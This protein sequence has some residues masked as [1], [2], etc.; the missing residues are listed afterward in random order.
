MGQLDRAVWQHAV[1]VIRRQARRLQKSLG[2]L[3]K[4]HY[5]D[6]LIA[7][8]YF[9]CVLHDRPVSWGADREHYDRRFFRPGPLPSRSQFGR[10]VNTPRFDRLL[11]MIHLDLA[12]P[13]DPAEGGLF[14]GKPLT[15]GVASKDPE[16]ARGKVMGGWA[17]GYKLHIWTTFGR[18]I[19][20]WSLQPLNVAEPLVA[21]ALIAAHPG[22]NGQA[23]SLGDG[24]FDCQRLYEA[25][26]AKHGCLLAKPRGMDLRDP[27]P[28]LSQQAQAH[29]KSKGGGPVRREVM[30]AWRTLPEIAGYLYRDRIHV[31]GTLSNLCSYAGGLGPLPAWVRRTQRV[32]RWV[33]VKISLYHARLDALAALREAA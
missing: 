1:Q 30:A 25:V 15:V 26:A 19:L 27:A 4:S 33:G 9:W 20:L 23:V 2:P 29:P 11:G 8:M 18:R 10:R 28:W 32:R 21:E 14:D 31:E 5:A 24:N 7:R 17:K 16:A 6:A 12:G 3:A 22:F 13:V